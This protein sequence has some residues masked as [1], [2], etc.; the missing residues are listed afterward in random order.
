MLKRFG[1]IA[2]TIG[3]LLTV[4]APAAFAAD[5][6]P[7]TGSVLA[8]I[9]GSV[10]VAA[11]QHVD[12]L[13]VVGGTTNVA[14][15]VTTIVVVNGSATLANATARD[16]LVVDGTANLEG[17]TVVSGDVRTIHGTIERQSGV[18]VQ[19][20]TTSLD[21]DL[22][23][24][25]VLLAGLL[26]AIFLGVAVAV[27]AFALLVAGL[28]GRQVRA[29]EGIITAEPGRALVTGLVAGIGLPLLAVLLLVTVVG[30]PV[31]VALFILLSPLTFLAWIVAAMWVG[32]WI[33]A[34]VR[35]AREPERPYRAALVGVIVLA[36][37]GIVP[38][39]SAIATF[40]GLGA[41]LLAG[42]RGL[43]RSA[44]AAPAGVANAI[45]AAS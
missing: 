36:I 13:L 16:V 23:A 14:G 31:G 6:H 3:L 18:V 17:S 40:F 12:T 26:L 33:V 43:G 10:D 24:L 35:G 7:A 15:D 39:V 42:W 21:A 20:S 19:G 44:P 8:S 27:L 45:P 11:G 41:L 9:N 30:A 34:R 5:R 22:A 2:V 1:L 32:D 29:V 37:A 25:A 4:F 38:F 28:A